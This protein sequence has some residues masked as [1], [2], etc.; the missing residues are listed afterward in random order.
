M[1]IEARRP[2]SQFP[3][4]AVNPGD[5]YGNTLAQAIAA[6]LNREFPPTKPQRWR[7]P[8]LPTRR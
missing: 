7:G 4:G 8:C 1:R 2:T 3:Q 6:G 5:D